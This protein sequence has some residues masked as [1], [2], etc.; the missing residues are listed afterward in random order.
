MYQLRETR[1]FWLVVGEKLNQIRPLAPTIW[2]EKATEVIK[3][4]IYSTLRTEKGWQEDKMSLRTLPPLDVATP[5]LLDEFHKNRTSWVIL[6]DDG[7][8]L[9]MT[10][11]DSTVKLRRV[12]TGEL[13]KSIPLHKDYRHLSYEYTG[14]GV[15]LALNP[16]E[17]D[18]E[19]YAISHI[20]CPTS[21]NLAIQTDF[22][23]RDLEYSFQYD[24][25]SLYVLSRG[26]GL[27]LL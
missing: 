14:T 21:S 23:L 2:R 6:L 8:H 20:A 16:S 10:E 11:R 12:D 7:N 5:L 13:V 1:I 3:T 26:P 27:R 17:Y 9:L 19:R 25:C 24:P 4:S 22:V 15:V 18:E